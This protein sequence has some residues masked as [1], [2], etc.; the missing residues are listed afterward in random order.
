M[1]DQEEDEAYEEYIK[2]VTRNDK[3]SVIGQE[4]EWRK[5]S[6]NDNS[7]LQAPENIFKSNEI[8][9]SKYTLWSFVPKNLFFQFQK[10]ANMYFLVLMCF[11]MIPQ[12]TISN[13]TPTIAMPLS[14]VIFVSMVKDII[15]DSKRHSSDNKENSSKCLCIPREDQTRLVN[16]S[17]IGV[18][19]TLKWSQ[20][21]VGQI[22]KVRKDEYFPADII[23]LNSNDPQGIA[24]VET[25]NLDGETNMKSKFAHKRTIPCTKT[26]QDLAMFSGEIH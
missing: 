22:V 18:F 6:F 10:I 23:L 17:E 15:E 9:T 5:F 20:L 16:H 11:Q 26:D 1:N 25:K 19:K 4:I 24:F 21:K 12:I 2:S 7:N 14:F 8:H 3:Q 13:G